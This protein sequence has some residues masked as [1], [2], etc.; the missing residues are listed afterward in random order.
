[1]TLKQRNSKR[2][3]CIKQIGYDPCISEETRDSIVELLSRTRTI[4]SEEFTGMRLTLHW[5]VP[6]ASSKAVLDAEDEITKKY[7]NA[8]Y[9]HYFIWNTYQVTI[10][11]N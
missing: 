11:A 2:D 7:G 3:E 5:G 8:P 10:G 9:N 4:V 1:M 6:K